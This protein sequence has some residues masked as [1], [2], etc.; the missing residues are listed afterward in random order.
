M[1]D[2]I[3]VNQR[4]VSLENFKEFITDPRIW[5]RLLFG[6]GT[7]FLIKNL[8][9]DPEYESYIPNDIVRRYYDL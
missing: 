6:R 7:I 5:P 8:L 4:T 3:R 9:D 1:N 2:E